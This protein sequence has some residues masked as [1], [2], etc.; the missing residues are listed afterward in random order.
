ME[1]TLSVLLS[2]Q[3]NDW[4]TPLQYVEAARRVMG[5]IDLDPASSAQ[6]N[7]IVK[8]NAFFD[9]AANGLAQGWTGR[10]FLNPPYGK[11]GGT[12]SQEIW[13]RK[14]I[15]EYRAGN[16]EQAIALVNFV[17]G[18]KWWSP[19]WQFPLCAVDHCIRF[20]RA[21]GQPSGS[22][23]ASSAFVYLG[24]DEQRFRTEFIRFGPVGRF[25]RGQQSTCRICSEPITAK[26][27]GGRERIYCGP[28]CKQKA[29]RRRAV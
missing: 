11:Q 1:Q 17:P 4:Y 22:A 14:L 26:E 5:G 15:E 25:Y 2:S 8:A 13:T 12:S 3:S 27:W 24:R 6:A 21:D 28:A 7:Q 16:V 20:L 9:E 23:K 29:Y 18:Y 19:L 10:I